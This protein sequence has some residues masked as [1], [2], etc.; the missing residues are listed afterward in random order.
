MIKSQRGKHKFDK[1][2]E[3]L[4]V[5]HCFQTVMSAFGVVGGGQHSVRKAMRRDE[6][7]ERGEGH[8]RQE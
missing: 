8:S 2:H 7:R 5:R 1:D 6:E 4:L 3:N